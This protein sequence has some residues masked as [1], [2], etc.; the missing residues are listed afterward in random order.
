[1]QTTMQKRE[2]STVQVD[3]IVPAQNFGVAIERAYGRERGRY[4]VQ[5]FRKGYAPRKLIER[6][7]GADVFYDSA[8]EDLAPA[9]LEEACKEHMLE[10]VGKPSL[11]VEHAKEGEE[12]KISF[13]FAVYPE[14]TL[15]LYKG[16][17]IERVLDDVSNESVQA[18]LEKER[19]ARVRYIET[20]RPIEMGDRIIFDYKG[21]IGDEYF[22]GGAA[23]KAQLDIGSGQFIPGF[24]DAMIGVA[25]NENR[26]IS[27]KFPDGYQAEHL[28]GK[29]ATFEVFVHEIRK[30][31]LPEIDD[32]LAMD[33]SDFDTLDAWKEDISRRLKHEAEH[34]AEQTMQNEA[35][36][37]AAEN[38]TI[39]IP[40][41]MVDAQVD[42]IIRDYA[43]RLSY[44]GLKLED[45]LQYAGTT[46]EQMRSDVRGEAQHRVRNQLVLDGITKMEGI[47]AEPEEIDARVA[48]LAA[49]YE[50]PVEEFAAQ[51]TEKDREYIAEDVAIAKTLAFLLKNAVITEK[52]QEK[53]KAKTK[54]KAGAKIAEAETKDTEGAT[55]PKKPRTKKAKTAEPMEE[56]Q[57]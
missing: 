19:N 54:P 56:K 16:I 3:V 20:E 15:G 17:S 36:E 6:L 40:D 37:K 1:M 35:L 43:T 39:E 33:A 45:Y 4:S 27:V 38:A 10:I 28:A 12:L 42:N 11:S 49:Q 46:I 22:E 2:K 41:A 26:E 34:R 53:P 14:V 57:K 55:E 9:V 7:Y 52:P 44:Q 23:E 30:K 32:D 31:E 29:Q 18:E 13:S 48:E 8:I 51:L 47:K 24:E 21:K 50:R 25:P 5:G